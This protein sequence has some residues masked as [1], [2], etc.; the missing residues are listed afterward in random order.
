[1]A[2]SVVNTSALRTDLPKKNTFFICSLNSS[3]PVACG[4]SAARSESLET[5]SSHLLGEIKSIIQL[6]S[7]TANALL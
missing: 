6:L 4:I 3:I 7:P 1:M 5:W 2:A